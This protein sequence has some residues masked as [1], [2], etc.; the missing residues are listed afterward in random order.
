MFGKKNDL[1]W[2]VRETSIDTFGVLTTTE[3]QVY[4]F[5]N[6]DDAVEYADTSARMFEEVHEELRDGAYKTVRLA[7]DPTCKIVI[8]RTFDK[9]CGNICEKRILIEKRVLR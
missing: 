6:E 1:V 4:T 7:D 8:A 5:S 3:T 9:F 2:I